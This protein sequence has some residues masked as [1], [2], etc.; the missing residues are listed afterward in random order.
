[1]DPSGC[2]SGQ[3][4]EQEYLRYGAYGTVMGRVQLRFSDPC[5]IVWTR[6]C[7]RGIFAIGGHFYGVQV[8][9]GA[10][11]AGIGSATSGV[12]AGNDTAAPACSLSGY[13]RAT[14]TVGL[15]TDCLE[16]YN[17]SCL[18]WGEGG[19]HGQP[20][21]SNVYYSDHETTEKF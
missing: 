14:W 11:Y 1:M 21:Q 8:H 3:T 15:F 2:S 6:V 9:R 7:R 4:V 20:N 5:D 12:I 16:D 19:I 13:D 18:T 10:N 17:T